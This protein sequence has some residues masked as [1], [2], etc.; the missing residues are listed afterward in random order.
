MTRT[1]LEKKISEFIFVRP[2][3]IAKCQ[4]FSVALAEPPKKSTKTKSLYAKATDTGIDPEVAAKRLN[5]DWDSAAE[6][7]ASESDDDTEVP[8]AVV[9][10]GVDVQLFTYSH[11]IFLTMG[12]QG[13]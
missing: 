12:F 8:S 2:H 9:G 11:S 5:V 3:L 1:G 7:E 10:L 6:I 4:N 13:R